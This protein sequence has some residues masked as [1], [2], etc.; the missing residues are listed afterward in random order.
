MND[1]PKYRFS[2]QGL[3]SHHTTHEGIKKKK[4]QNPSFWTHFSFCSFQ[5]RNSLDSLFGF[6]EGY[7]IIQYYLQMAWNEQAHAA[8]AI[9]TG[10]H[11]HTF[12]LANPELLSAPR[13][14]LHTFVSVVPSTRSASLLLL[15]RIPTHHQQKAQSPACFK[16]SK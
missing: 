2:V 5:R 13:K 3:P 16:K 11:P 15:S 14:H 4:K 12:H 10:S 7:S 9:M 8:Q 6:L 1:F